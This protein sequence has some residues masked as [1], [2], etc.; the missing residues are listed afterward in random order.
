MKV[1][2]DTNVLVRSAVGDDPEQALLAAE[3]LV[4]AEIVF[5]ATEV[6]CEFVWVLRRGYRI[7]DAAIAD[8]IRKLIDAPNVRADRLA[9]EAGIAMLEAGGD[10]AD[11]VIAYSG[12]IAGADMFVS[13][14]R[15]A[16]KALK[17]L[18]ENAHDLSGGVPQDIPR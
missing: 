8:A 2:A 17:T 1:A 3:L 12:R 6:L 16:I 5:V 13:F 9:A 18:G 4:N 11:G 15:Q 14:D 10:F 7:E